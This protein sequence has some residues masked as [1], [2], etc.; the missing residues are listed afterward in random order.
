MELLDRDWFAVFGVFAAKNGAQAANPDLVQHAKAT[1]G[2][3]RNVGGNFPGQGWKPIL[4]R[5]L[6]TSQ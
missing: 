6:L 2:R 3:R 4:S 5:N 1:E